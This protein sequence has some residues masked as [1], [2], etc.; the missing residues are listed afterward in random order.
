MSFRLLFRA[1]LVFG[2]AVAIALQGKSAVASP[3][4]GSVALASMSPMSAS[5]VTL[6]VPHQAP[7][8]FYPPT[9]R[10]GKK[11][12]VVWVHGRGGNPE[13]DC[14]KWAGVVRE[15]G[16]LL[17]PSGGEDRGGGA[18]GWNNNWPQAKGTIEAAFNAL[19][20][21]H[22]RFIP[23]KGH[24]LIGFSEGALIAMNVGVR[25]PETFN[26]WLIL[27]ANDV[28]WGGE[29]LS[30]LK[31]SQ[32]KIRRVYL[33]TG[34]Q[35]GVVDNTR[36]V[37]ESMEKENVKVR[38]WTPED[39]GHEVPADRMQTFYRRPLRWLMTSK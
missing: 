7:A 8:Y 1:S 17:C 26:R 36:R 5:P 20:A 14:R 9:S 33:L 6:E 22:S 21:K 27:A 30:E 2:G 32:R 10:T 25:D 18:R 31:K 3:K 4:I 16:W 34:G 11:H 12:V 15:H 24:T 29:G 38:M 35:D 23:A 19:R 28:Y 39:I 13:A 37:F